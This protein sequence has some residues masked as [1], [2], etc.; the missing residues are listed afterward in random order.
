MLMIA[1]CKSVDALTK[2]KDTVEMNEKAN[3]HPDNDSSA[4]VNNEA[5]DPGDMIHNLPRFF[6]LLY[7][8]NLT[9][10]QEVFLQT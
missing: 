8:R 6:H 1:I 2:I 3:D 7:G 10:S 4:L 5:T 9:S